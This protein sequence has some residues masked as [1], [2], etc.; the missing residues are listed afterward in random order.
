MCTTDKHSP[1]QEKGRCH[2]GT[3]CD[4][5][6]VGHDEITFY[7][8]HQDHEGH[9]PLK[10]THTHTHESSSLPSHTSLTNVTLESDTHCDADVY[11]SL[12]PKPA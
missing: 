7:T 4:G 9:C 6:D 11:S 5:Y 10:N 8:H 3:S 1:G 12:F 2:T